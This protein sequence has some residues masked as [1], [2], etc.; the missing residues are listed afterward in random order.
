MH[1][2]PRVAYL[3]CPAGQLESP[4]AAAVGKVLG[5]AVTARNWTTMTKLHALVGT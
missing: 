4:L 5:D 3:W 2:G 1:V